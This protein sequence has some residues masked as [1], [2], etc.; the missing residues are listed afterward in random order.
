MHAVLAVLLSDNAVL[1]GLFMTPYG[2]PAIM[3]STRV[4]FCVDMGCSGLHGTSEALFPNSPPTIFNT[5]ISDTI[6]GRPSSFYLPTGDLAYDGIGN[7]FANKPSLGI[8]LRDWTNHIPN[9]LTLPICP[10]CPAYTGVCPSDQ[11]AVPNFFATSSDPVSCRPMRTCAPSNETGQPGTPTTDRTCA[12]NLDCDPGEYKLPTTT[13]RCLRCLTGKFGQLGRYCQPVQ[14]ACET[15]GLVELAA[16]TPTS[17]R[18]CTICRGA[19][20]LL[21]VAGTSRVQCGPCGADQYIQGP[22]CMDDTPCASE[23]YMSEPKTPFSPTVCQPARRCQPSQYAATPLT[24]T[25][26]RVCATCAPGTFSNTIN[27]VACVPWTT[28]TS[29]QY[30]CNGSFPNSSTDRKCCNANV[31]QPNQYFNITTQKCV[32]LSNCRPGSYTSTPSTLTNDRLVT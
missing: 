22:Y 10:G 16:P 5:D 3:V 17:D 1:L 11:A 15:R 23:H 27:Q 7:P 8:A 18:L 30:V 6:S 14:P 31:C 13:G 28:C 26:D 32:P 20:A 29:T 25:A 4:L 12:G 2:R 19:Q 21:P 24:A 9:G